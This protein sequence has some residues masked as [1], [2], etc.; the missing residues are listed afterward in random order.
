MNLLTEF[1]CSITM[2]D[3]TQVG[4]IYVV[5]QELY[6]LGLDLVEKL[7]LDA[8][9]MNVFC[10]QVNDS[11]C[12]MVERLKTAYPQVFSTSFGRC[13]KTTVKL[14][15]KP[16]QLP[17]FR[18]KRSV[19]YAMYQ[20]VDKELDRLKIITP[21]DYSDWAAPIVVVRK[22]SGAIRICG[23]SSTGL[24]DALQPNQYPLPLPQNI[25]DKLANCKVFSIIDMS[26]SYLQVAVRR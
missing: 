10:R 26:E 9:P 8:V 25:F 2:N 14:D 3:I 23:D 21:T 24:N 4:T 13:T 6:I 19:A 15:L 18:P 20:A 16:D 7:K 17:V 22:A 5:S 1:D 12:S 11:S